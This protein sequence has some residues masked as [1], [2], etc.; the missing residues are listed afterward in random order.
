MG[1]INGKVGKAAAL[2][3]FSETLTHDVL[4]PIKKWR[5]F[6]SEQL[7]RQIIHQNSRIFKR[8]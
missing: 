1:A 6:C 2:P 5:P 8:N 3:K 4:L 7:Q